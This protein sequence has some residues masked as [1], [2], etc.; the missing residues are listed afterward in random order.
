MMPTTTNLVQAIRT[1]RKGFH[2]VLVYHPSDEKCLSSTNATFIKE[3]QSAKGPTVVGQS[4]LVEFL[5]KRSKS[6][7]SILN[8]SAESLMQLSIKYSE[9]PDPNQPAHLPGSR[10]TGGKMK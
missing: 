6:L 7:G 1:M 8:S 2:H 5:C 10:W 3:T 4:D 9:S